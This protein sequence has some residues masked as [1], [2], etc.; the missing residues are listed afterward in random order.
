MITGFDHVV[1]G[2]S[3]IA[4]RVSAYEALLGERATS[5]TT[6]DDVALAVVKTSN[7]AVELMAPV[8][9]GASRL[10]AAIDDGGEGIKSLVF[11][12]GDVDGARTR[13]ERVGLAPE[14]VVIGAGYRS[15]RVS[16][17]RTH[18][19]RLFF[20]ERNEAPSSEA[21]H[22]GLDH[23]VIRTPE[24]ERAAALY[25]A[26]LGLDMRLD[27]EVVGRRLMFFR[28]G[29]AIVEIIHDETLSDGRDKLWGLSWRVADAVHERERLAAAGFDVSDVR[30]GMKPG[31]RVFTVRD[32]TCGVPTLMIESNPKRD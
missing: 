2:V 30:V 4:N 26:R 27:R 32:R 13:C 18:G 22:R 19:V 20:L 28:C 31:T 29:S 15:F 17:E 9:P 16:T 21:Q 5:V 8:G 23:I 10:Q 25:G 12:V 24:P 3:D 6:N 11:A 1:L 7:I 14:P